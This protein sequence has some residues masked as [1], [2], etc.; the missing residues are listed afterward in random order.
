MKLTFDH[1]LHIHSYISPCGGDPTQTAEKILSYA[2][3]NNLKCVCVTD[4][5]WDEK[6]PSPLSFDFNTYERLNAI[7]PLPQS[8]N[9]RFLFGCEADLD[10]NGKIGISPE[11]MSEFD[12]IVVATTHFHHDDKALLP[13]DRE[14]AQARANAW[15]KRFDC[16]LNYDL[17]HH[18]VGLA[19]M[20]TACM[21]TTSY[22]R[23]MEVVKAIPENE[24][25]RLFKRA[26]ELEIGIE[27]NREAMNFPLEDEDA[28]KPYFLAKEC[29]C[30]FYC[31]SDAH[32]DNGLKQAPGIYARAL[33]FLDFDESDQYDF[34]KL[35]S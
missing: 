22:E 33:P 11:R 8:E 2:T 17:P 31:G 25:I 34:T 5:F 6:I 23:M 9:T 15:V 19:H 29:G 1:D 26:A 24:M 32:N 27:L 16:L 21:E 14:S 35:Y 4:H 18:K 10:V 3:E 13:Q 12:F 28:W 20:T 7:R 30:K